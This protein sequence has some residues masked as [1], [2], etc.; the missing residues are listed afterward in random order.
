M[1]VTWWED[2]ADNAD[3][4]LHLGEYSFGISMANDDDIIGGRIIS[5]AKFE[6]G[7]EF[8][9]DFTGLWM[10]T[11]RSPAPPTYDCGSVHLHGAAVV[12]AAVGAR[13]ADG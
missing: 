3:Y 11:S 1:R 6:G 4:I 10:L 8:K 5:K 2:D 12:G 9:T 13:P 7:D